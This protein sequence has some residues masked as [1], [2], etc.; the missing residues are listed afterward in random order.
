[1]CQI[2]WHNNKNRA[3]E[4][5]SKQVQLES[6]WELRGLDFDCWNFVTFS[7]PSWQGNILMYSTAFNACEE[8]LQF[9]HS[10]QLLGHLQDALY[11]VLRKRPAW[12]H[13][14]SGCKLWPIR[15]TGVES[16]QRMT[17]AILCWEG[18]CWWRHRIFGGREGGCRWLGLILTKFRCHNDSRASM[19]I[20]W[21]IQPAE[22][23]GLNPVFFLNILWPSKT[24]QNLRIVNCLIT[25]ASFC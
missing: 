1:M 13:R 15:E 7:D 20:R 10:S 23:P 5:R 14:V 19:D 2:G 12:M 6:F 11:T 17:I 9:Q 21:A 25:K 4:Q 3:R 16:V 18:L 22:S 24:I 8:G